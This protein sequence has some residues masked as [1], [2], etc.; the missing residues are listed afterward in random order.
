VTCSSSFKLNGGQPAVR[1]VIAD[2][3]TLFREALRLVLA[4]EGFSV[5][6]EAADGHEAVHRVVET[7]PDVLLLDM[8][9]PRAGGLDALRQLASR[10][11]SVKT[12][13]F[14]A[15]ISTDDVVTALTLGAY[16]VVLKDIDS[17][18]LCDC[19]RAV[20]EGQHWIRHQDIRELVSVVRRVPANGTSSPTFPEVLTPRERQVMAAVLEGAT[21]RD[22]SAQLQM[23][24]QT[25][26]NHLWRVFDKTGV[27]SRLE[28]ALYASRHVV[29]GKPDYDSVRQ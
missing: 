17:P 14:T 27:S 20:A 24:T 5:V 13:I 6:G 26:K 16:G 22:I 1:V 15:A 9:M 10:N 23:S 25:V 8:Q 3:Q 12:V 21:N 2:D 4:A 18:Q 19:V 28:L 7:R 11:I 29:P